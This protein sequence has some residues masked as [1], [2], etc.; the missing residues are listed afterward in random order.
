[1]TLVP[2]IYTSLLIFTALLFIV[3]LFSYLSYK[4]KSR[5]KLPKREVDFIRYSPV[6]VVQPVYVKSNNQVHRQVQ[7]QP[8][9][10]TAK[11]PVQ[12]K[13]Q[14]QYQ[15]PR[16]NSRNE[17]RESGSQGQYLN[18]QNIEDKNQ[19]PRSL[20][21]N[22]EKMRFQTRIEIMNESEKF[23]N[24]KVRNNPPEPALKRASRSTGLSELNVLNYY[25]DVEN[26]DLVSLNASHARQAM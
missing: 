9:I 20:T 15:N 25:S 11:R 5:G 13:A 7:V 23:R 10:Q 6:P 8:V 21:E 24:T 19:R 2:I 18:T 16:D 17:R 22:R 1:M 12:N 3:I 26:T 4:A 14:E